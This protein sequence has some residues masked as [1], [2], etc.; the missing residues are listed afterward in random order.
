M[1]L[2]GEGEGRRGT[3]GG[4]AANPDQREASFAAIVS[5]RCTLRRYIYV[6]YGLYTVLVN[7][8]YSNMYVCGKCILLV[9]G[10]ACC[11]PEKEG[12]TDEEET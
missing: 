6:Q 12:V 3:A 8:T 9:E 2:H 5:A 1:L 10:H 7:R 11:A 4:R